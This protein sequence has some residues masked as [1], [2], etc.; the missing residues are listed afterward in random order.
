M[1]SRRA[2]H[3]DKCA[4]EKQKEEDVSESQRCDIS[5]LHPDPLCAVYQFYYLFTTTN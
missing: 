2:H 4:K 1:H 5:F 3:H